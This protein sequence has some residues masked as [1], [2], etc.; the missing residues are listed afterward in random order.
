[1]QAPCAKYFLM[2]FD[3]QGTL[4]RNVFAILTMWGLT[5]SQAS[6]ALGLRGNWLSDLFR[7]DRRSISLSRLD[8]VAEY[9][10]VEPAVLIDSGMNHVPDKPENK[11]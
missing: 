5:P 11:T 8:A 10:G 3:S 7:R 1:M 2:K 9:L 6:S 4:K